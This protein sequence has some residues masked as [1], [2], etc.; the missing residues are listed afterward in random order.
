[1]IIELMVL[2]AIWLVAS[3]ALGVVI[4][5]MIKQGSGE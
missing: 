1:M 3:F 4:G 5:M 2:L